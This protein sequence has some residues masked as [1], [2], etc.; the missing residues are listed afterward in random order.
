MDEVLLGDASGSAWKYNGMTVHEQ[1]MM[2]GPTPMGC[3]AVPR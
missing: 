1:D 2:V 3:S